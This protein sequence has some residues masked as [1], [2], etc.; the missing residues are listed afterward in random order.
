MKPCHNV[1]KY[2]ETI[3]CT[4]PVQKHDRLHATDTCII[5]LQYSEDIHITNL[6]IYE[7][8]FLN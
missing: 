8:N 7:D 1:V 6:S 5:I 3:V 4:L 2:Y